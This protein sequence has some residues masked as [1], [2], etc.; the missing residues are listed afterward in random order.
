MAEAF[1][2]ILFSVF[3]VFG[4]YSAMRETKS[5][6]RKLSKHISAIDKYKK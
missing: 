2:E 6:L 4:L 5:I 1:L 3:F